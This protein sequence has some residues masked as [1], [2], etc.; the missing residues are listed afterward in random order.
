VAGLTVWNSLPDNL[1]HP[2]AT[3]DKAPD[4]SVVFSVRTSTISALDVLK[5]IIAP[6]I[7]VLL[8]YLR[9]ILKCID[10]PLAYITP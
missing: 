6:Q 3:M 5:Q 1:L 2:D 8:T 10:I 9:L 7:Y 4:E